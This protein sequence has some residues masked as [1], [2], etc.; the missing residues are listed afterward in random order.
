[1]LELV[2]DYCGAILTVVSSILF[3]KIVLHEKSHISGLLLFLI[4]ILVAL[5]LQTLYVLD[6]NI[7]RSLISFILFSSM[8]KIVYSTD[9]YKALLLG[10]F[11]IIS[12]A[13]SDVLIILFFVGIF[14]EKFFYE[15]LAGTFFSNLFVSII[16]V[17]IGYIL[18][19]VINRLFTIKLRSKLIIMSISVV[20][21]VVYLFYYSF[22][23]VV[24]TLNSLLG[25]F[26]ILI[27][28]YA[29]FYS[30]NQAYKNNQLMLEYDNLL[31]FIK[32]Y[33]VEIDNQRM[34]RHETKNQ[35]LTIKSK[36]IDKEKDS[37][38]VDYIDEIIHDDRKVN[39]SEYAK[40]KYL[41]SN[42]IRG[43]FYFKMSLAEDKGIK[44][45][46]SIS[47]DIENSIL[48][49]LD[50][51]NFNQIGKVL[52]VYLDNAIEG[53]IDS[54]KKL[55]G[56]EAFKNGD[57]IIFV[58]SNSY[59]PDTRL[60]G[61]SSKGVGRGYGLLL[62]GNIIKGN[63]MLSDVTEITEELYIKKLIIKK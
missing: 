7:T 25:L 55:I 22:S 12:L 23:M 52:G 28:A 16:V 1:M 14:G 31:S 38:V 57:K 48:G 36:I 51:S 15:E 17:L 30:F 40:L 46:V 63:A 3:C 56:I 13:I 54:E 8:F 62:A 37:A 21:C 6:A 60:N 4:I 35:L 20:I 11:Y 61:R 39:H 19:K 18:K 5:I 27:L 45:S 32:K 47:K 26:C 44:M 59:N 43:L 33:E 42:G 49:S 10:V 53:A 58:I 24:P 29:L 50:S 41:P 34:L 9:Y 2:S